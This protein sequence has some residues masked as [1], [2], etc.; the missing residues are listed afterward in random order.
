M[1]H[2]EIIRGIE[3]IKSRGATD[4]DA[5]TITDLDASIAL[6]E[7]RRQGPVTRHGEP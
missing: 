5:A 1:K 7:T 4:H 2:H 3:S 6:C